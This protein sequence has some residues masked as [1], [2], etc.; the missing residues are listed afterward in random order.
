MTIPA[1]RAADPDDIDGLLDLARRGGAGITSLPPHA[2]HLTARLE[3]SEIAFGRA[4]ARP[5]GEEYLFVADDGGGRLTAT[6]TVTSRVGGFDPFYTYEI[7]AERVTHPP[8]GVDRAINVLHL[9]RDH[10]GPSELCGLV[11]DPELRGRGL[12]RL[13]S[14][15]RLLYVAAHPER[16]ADRTIA[17]IRGFQ[18]AAGD[19]PF[20]D[21]VGR[22]FLSPSGFAEADMLTGLGEKDFVADLMPRHPI[23]VDLLSPEVRGI[24]GRPHREAVPAMR[25]LCGEGFAPARE[26][27]IFDAGPILECPTAAIRCVRDAERMILA[28][29]E[30]PAGGVP[31]LIATLRAPFR[32]IRSEALVDDRGITLT[33]EAAARL[34]VEPGDEL[35]AIADGRPGG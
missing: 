29:I 25:L 16:F 26:V 34:G 12:G 27:D 11:V 22:V 9:K 30:E 7:R 15:G 33:R 31:H 13:A 19:S 17:E 2:D 24:I 3:R 21:A 23:Y 5:G 32:A 8:L 1:L 20:W 18:D 14:L 35:M 10:K 28:C 6:A 4:P